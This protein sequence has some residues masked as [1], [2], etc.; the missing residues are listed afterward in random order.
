MLSTVSAVRVAA[1]A[2]RS[3]LRRGPGRGFA[4][5]AAAERPR[6]A[7][8]HRAVSRRTVLRRVAVVAGLPPVALA[9]AFAAATPPA[10]AD[11][12][13]ERQLPALQS[14]GVLQAHQQ[15]TGKGVTVAVVDS[16]VDPRH[17][18]LAGSVVTG[19]DF[20]KGANPPGVPPARVHGTFMASLVAGH[21]HG[22]GRRN[23]VIGVA[24]A[25][26]ILSI[27]VAPERQEP[28]FR[29]FN[30]KRRFRNAVAKGIRHAADKGADVINL[31]LGKSG[32][33]AEE[34]AAVTH[35][36]KRGAVVVAAVGNDGDS[37]KVDAEGLAPFSY[38]A[39][40]PGVVAVAA[41]DV[42]K[43]PAR[44][45]NR[46][47][48][49]LVAAPGV[50]VVGAGPNRQYLIG[51]GTSQAT[52]LVSGVAALIRA[53]HPK[54]SPAL[55]SQAIVASAVD[56]PSGGYDVTVGFG[57]VDAA[58]ALA[59]ADKLAGYKNK[60][61]IPADRRVSGEEAAEPVPVVQRDPLWLGGYVGTAGFALLGF[62]ASAVVLTVLNRRTRRPAAAGAP[63][64]GDGFEDGDR[65]GYLG[66]GY[67]ADPYPSGRAAPG[68]GDPGRYGG[69]PYGA[70]PR[71]VGR[72]GDPY[73]ARRHD[74]LPGE[75][76]RSGGHEPPAGGYGWGTSGPYERPP[77]RH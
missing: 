34:R 52:A 27:R 15:S 32:A 2:A 75:A 1:R 19:P 74:A 9:V 12:V 31:S 40:L 68:Y 58:R 11:Q 43:R 4:G 28:G 49:V 50:S 17:P 73:A 47:A 24:P 67:G 72:L 23:G 18:D 44:F 29:A 61:G 70:E 56:G 71:D 51:D 33:T 3:A 42:N 36:I 10:Q 46:N 60:A 77:S 45:S 76:H 54:M 57:T 7:A 14:L 62:V 63:F 20:T 25:A 26:K 22:P 5:R 8:S 66:E 65:Y 64:D 39:A 6:R 41:V 37:N 48:S 35:A 59:A 53:K 69:D 30:S 21:G 38:P 55:V 16:G 13:R